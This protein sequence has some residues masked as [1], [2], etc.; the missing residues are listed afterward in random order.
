MSDRKHNTYGNDTDT[1]E[2]IGKSMKM[3]I[4]ETGVRD[5]VMDLLGPLVSKAKEESEYSRLTQMRMDAIQKDQI[6][7]RRDIIALQQIDSSIK[8]MIKTQARDAAEV[9]SFKYSNEAEFKKVN[10]Y[11]ERLKY[12][13]EQIERAHQIDQ[14][15]I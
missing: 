9:K 12:L 3:Y 2:D 5:I 7:Q 1:P 6:E 4:S 10:A 15:K 14:D 8:E 11:A 13:M